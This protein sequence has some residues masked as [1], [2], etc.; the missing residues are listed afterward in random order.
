MYYCANCGE[1]LEQDQTFCGKCGTARNNKEKIE[2]TL[3]NKDIKI[4]N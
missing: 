3:E 1:N 4:D 2:H